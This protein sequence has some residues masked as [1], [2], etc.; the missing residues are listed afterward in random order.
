MMK[1]LLAAVCVCSMLLCGCQSQGT[2]LKPYAGVTASKTADVS[3]MIDTRVW[4]GFAAD[5]GVVSV[6]DSENGIVLRRFL[7]LMPRKFFLPEQQTVQYSL[8]IIF[9]LRCR[10]QVLPRY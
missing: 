7:R 6:D 3:S 8:L 4:E 10:R 5:L 1:K 2:Y 9:I